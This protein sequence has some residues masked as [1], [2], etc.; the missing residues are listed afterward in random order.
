MAKPLPRIDDAAI[1]KQQLPERLKERNQDHAQ[2]VDG[3]QTQL[4]A[5]VNVNVNLKKREHQ[6]MMRDALRYLQDR[7][8]TLNDGT[9]VTDKT[10]AMI[11][12]LENTNLS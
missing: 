6:M 11:W 2:S 8:E 10:K 9:E 7:G 12:L 3:Y 5:F 4:A 1:V